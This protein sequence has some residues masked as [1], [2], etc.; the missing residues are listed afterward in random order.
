M[1]D[2]E[3]AGKALKAVRGYIDGDTSARLFGSLRQVV[4]GRSWDQMKP[5]LGALGMD[6]SHWLHTKEAAKQTTLY[7]RLQYVIEHPNKDLIV[8][9][10]MM[11]FASFVSLEDHRL[12]V[13]VVAHYLLHL[14][15]DVDPYDWE[16]AGRIEDLVFETSEALKKAAALPHEAHTKE[17]RAI[18]VDFPGGVGH[19]VPTNAKPNPNFRRVTKPPAPGVPGSV[20]S[21]A[22]AGPVTGSGSGSGDGSAAVMLI[23]ILIVGVGL[24]MR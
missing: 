10:G 22:G 1:S 18:I 12:F 4:S 23:L 2:S 9:T 17:A 3:E 11:L 7:R 8:L 13:H 21:G 15:E 20:S 24:A 5:I 14:K 6:N 16:R 19:P